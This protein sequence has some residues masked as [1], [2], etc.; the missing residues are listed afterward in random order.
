MKQKKNYTGFTANTKLAFV[1][2]ILSCPADNDIHTIPYCFNQFKPIENF[3]HYQLDVSICNSRVVMWCSW[4]LFIFIRKLYLTLIKTKECHTP[5]LNTKIQNSIFLISC[6]ILLD[7]ILQSQGMHI[8][9]HRGPRHGVTQCMRGS[10]N[11]GQ[12][13][14]SSD[15]V[16]FLF[17]FF[18]FF[19]F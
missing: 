1:R 19:F 3:H 9:L 12:R 11:F 17:F 2:G 15:N 18:L 7:V 4:F 14:S 10:R 5:T 16:F 6:N 8:I 13:G